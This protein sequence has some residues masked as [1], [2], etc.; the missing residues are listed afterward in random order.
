[1]VNNNFGSPVYQSTV[2]INANQ[3]YDYK[4]IYDRISGLMRVYQNNNLIGNWTVG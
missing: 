2:T 1:V 3:A 4:V